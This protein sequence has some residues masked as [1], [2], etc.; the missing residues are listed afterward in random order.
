MYQNLANFV[1]DTTLFSNHVFKEKMLA[2]MLK[3]ELGP[4]PTRNSSLK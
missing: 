4:L 1:V 2:F 3:K